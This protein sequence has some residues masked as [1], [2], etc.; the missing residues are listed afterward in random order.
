[1]GDREIQFPRRHWLAASFGIGIAGGLSGCLGEG[2]VDVDEVKDEAEEVEYGA[3]NRNYE[4]YIGEYVYFPRVEINIRNQR[5][6]E[7][8]YNVRVQGEFDDPMWVR[9]DE[10]FL[11][12]DW[13]ELW[14]ELVEITNVW[15][16]PQV[17]AVE[18]NQ[19]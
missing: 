9:Y 10:R 6:N 2:N 18:M 17:N 11:V 5:D 15:D 12:D 4:E 1:M 7:Y 8:S 16:V 13:V 14:G 19:I 3:L